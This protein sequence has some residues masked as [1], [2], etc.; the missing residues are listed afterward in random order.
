M[1]VQIDAALPA[2][3]LS[4]IKG[5][6]PLEIGYDVNVKAF[7]SSNHK[8]SRRKMF[9]NHLQLVC[10]PSLPMPAGTERHVRVHAKIL[11][12]HEVPVTNNIMSVLFEGKESQVSLSTGTLDFGIDFNTENAMLKLQLKNP[13]PAERGT[14]SVSD[15]T[16]IESPNK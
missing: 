5:R 9:S 11:D 13:E 2:D 14:I 1:L 16:Y 15:L 12:V 10:E 3:I 8:E 7:Y 6:L 4:L